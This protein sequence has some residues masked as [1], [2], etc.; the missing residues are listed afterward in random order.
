MIHKIVICD[1]ESLSIKA[2]KQ[3]VFETAKKLKK[4]VEVDTYNNGNDIMRRISKNEPF[5][6]LILDIDMPKMTGLELAEKLCGN[7]KELIIIFLTA[8]EKYVY[9]AFE[10]QPFRYIRKNF[11]QKELPIALKSAFSVIKA[12]ADR[13]IT[14]K[15]D[16]DDRR[17]LLSE[18]MYYELSERK[19]VLYL[20]S[21]AKIITRK[22]I[23]EM[24]K[25][26]PD[27]RFIT[28]YRGCVVN[29]DYVKNIG[30]CMVIL[31]NEQKLIVS[32]LRM[33]EV[34]Q[35]LLKLWGELI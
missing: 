5:D 30:D 10:Y 26:I 16:G 11:I 31:D 4:Q 22:T 24:Q 27:N 13:E 7:K 14:I 12:K 8:H 25:I 9:Q 1:D 15:T 35:Q 18:V 33:K 28:L 3:V 29:A 21:G 17:I 6:I 34:K 32:R 2:A 19:I 23:K 20:N